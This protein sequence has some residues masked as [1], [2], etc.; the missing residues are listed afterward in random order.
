MKKTVLISGAGIAGPTL[1]YWLL[2]YGYAPTLCERASALRSGGY[3]VDFW[4]RGY[5]V[6]ERMG[7]IPTIEAAGYR[8]EEVRFV[9]AEGRRAGGFPRSAIAGAIGDR[10]TSLARSDLARALFRSVE[11][12]CETIFGDSVAALEPEAS[13]VRAV[14]GQGDERRFDLVIGADGLH[15]RVRELAFGPER[16][17]EKYLGYGVAAFEAKGYAP[18]NDDI[19]LAHSEPGRQLARF[20]MRGDR[21]LF[22]F[23]FA[24]GHFPE[25]EAHDAAGQKA[26]LRRLF[27]G[28][29]WEAPQILDALDATDDLYFDRVSQIRIDSWSKGRIALVGDAAYSVSLLAGQ[30]AALAMTGAYVLAGEIARAQGRPEIAFARYERTLRDYID[31]KQQA[32][33]RFASSFAPHTRW[34]IFIRN[35]LTKLMG[36]APIASLVFGR[37]LVDQLT[38]PEY[39]ES[40]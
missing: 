31:G 30:G 14:F 10:F 36:I 1:A 8:V 4:G 19:Y 20:S 5:D 39:A 9:D 12:D 28:D 3:I 2:R 21:T 6:A 35:Q 40:R 34:G 11:N 15:S 37:T 29:G 18:R 26:L 27:G 33:E 22:L 32:A 23:V 13:G 25:I 24:A 17:F 7:L 16:G 38:L